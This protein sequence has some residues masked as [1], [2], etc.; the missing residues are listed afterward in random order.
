MPFSTRNH[1]QKSGMSNPCKGE[2]FFFSQN[3]NSG[4]VRAFPIPYAL[5][6][7]IKCMHVVLISLQTNEGLTRL[8]ILRGFDFRYFRYS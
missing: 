5:R 7:C 1:K 4:L 2:Q 8:L 6:S 3:S